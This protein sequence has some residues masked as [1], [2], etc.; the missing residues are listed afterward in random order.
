[1][2]LCGVDLT[3]EHGFKATS[4][5]T[6]KRKGV[7]L[8]LLGIT[9]SSGAGDPRYRGPMTGGSCLRIEG[10]G[11]VGRKLLEVLWGHANVF[12]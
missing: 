1:M 10:W 2:S 9:G 12:G 3:G 8:R 5:V 7:I 6:L 11:T 4:A